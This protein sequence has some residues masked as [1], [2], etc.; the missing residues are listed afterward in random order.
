MKLLK[1][2]FFYVNL[3]DD[4]VLWLWGY[5]GRKL[6]IFMIFPLIHFLFVSKKDTVSDGHTFPRDEDCAAWFPM[7]QQGKIMQTKIKV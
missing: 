5:A 3:Q 7:E 1:G 4:V 2:A 6:T